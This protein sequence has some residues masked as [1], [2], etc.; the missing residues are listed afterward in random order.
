MCVFVLPGR[1]CLV[2]ASFHLPAL[3]VV[4]GS[5]QCQALAVSAISVPAWE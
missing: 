2:T 1:F 3:S 4:P 5:G